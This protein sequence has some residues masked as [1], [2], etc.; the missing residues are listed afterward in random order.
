MTRYQYKEYS[1]PAGQEGKYQQNFSGC[2][3][4]LDKEVCL[5]TEMSVNECLFEFS[6]ITQSWQCW[7]FCTTS[8]ANKLKT[9]AS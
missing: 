5:P 3:T 7:R 9:A 2:L 8:N 1:D 4:N 6:R